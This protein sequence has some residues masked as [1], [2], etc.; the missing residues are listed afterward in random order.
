MRGRVAERGRE[1]RR[2]V[3]VIAGG[4]GGDDVGI[5][6]VVSKYQLD[7][8]IRQ[9]ADWVVYRVLG[10]DGTPFALTRVRLGE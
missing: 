1:N 2:K 5:L 9:N 4:K 7:D 8:L 10:K 3:K 6:Q